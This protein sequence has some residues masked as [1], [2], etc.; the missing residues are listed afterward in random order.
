MDKKLVN[1]A[2]I[3]TVAQIF[4]TVFVKKSIKRRNHLN[5]PTDV[6]LLKKVKLYFWRRIKFIPIVANYRLGLITVYLIIRCYKCDWIIVNFK[7]KRRS[8]NYMNNTVAK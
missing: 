6:M 1:T 8:A 3:R 4:Y 5:K 2:V 7:L